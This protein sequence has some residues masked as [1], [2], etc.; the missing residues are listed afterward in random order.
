MDTNASAQ[1]ATY[2]YGFSRRQ[3]DTWRHETNPYTLIIR[4]PFDPERQTPGMAGAYGV[5]PTTRS[6]ASN[7]GN[8]RG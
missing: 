8:S 5:D 1:T 3:I 2:Y 7:V 4:S 6:T